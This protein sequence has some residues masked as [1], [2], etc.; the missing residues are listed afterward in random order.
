M[1][2]DYPE[3]SDITIMN[4]IYQYPRKNEETNKWSKGSMMVIAKDN[5]T[6][7]KF[8]DKEE[9]PKYAYY[10]AKE[11]VQIDHN[12]F[13]IE[14]DKVDKIEVPYI[15]LLKSIAENTDNLEFYY[16]NIKSGNRYNNTQLN[17]HPRVFSSDMSIDNF[18]R[19]E[20]SHKY[21]NNIGP[22][23]KSYLDIEADTI[24]M[25]GD[26]P[27]PGECPI[28]AV[29]VLIDSEET[30]YTFLLRNSENPLIEQFEKGLDQRF[31]QRLKD[32]VQDT[33]GGY[34]K[35]V[36]YKI[37]KL[38]YKLLFYDNE[39]DLLRDLFNLINTKEP[40]FV[41]AWN[42]A[43]DVPYII[44]RIINLGYNPEDII[45]HPDFEDKICRYYVDEKN[46][47][48]FAERGDF[49]TI[50]SYSTYV[51]QLVQFA[52]RRKGQSAF[53][54]MRLDDIGNAVAGVRKL[55]YAHITN[56][57]AKFPWL[58]YELFVM[59][60]IVDVIVQKC[61]E[62]SVGDIDYLFGKA[63]ANNTTYPKVHRQTVYLTNRAN[64]EFYK[65]GFIIGNNANRNNE[66]PPKFPGAF[67]A[68]PT[69]V[70]DYARDLINGVPVNIFRN[71]DDFDYKRLYP[72][73]LQEFNMAPNTQVGMIH[74]AEQIYAN[75]NRIKD[76]K[77]SRGGIYIENLASHNYLEF[78]KRWMHL[79]GYEDLYDD[80]IEYY[81]TIRN[82]NRMLSKV[83]DDGLLNVIHKCKKQLL[84]NPII[85][86]DN[87]QLRNV[88]VKYIPMDKKLNERCM[89]VYK[90]KGIV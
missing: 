50:S 2:I 8:Y 7:K 20:F 64:D 73:L 79:G 14:E 84:R 46:S 67:V 29:S 28:N 23:K 17:M 65:Q 9:N 18:V 35:A 5:V 82:S 25:A 15:D 76:D 34:K 75:E 33:V 26:F 43:F 86:V 80:I 81:T 30:M 49:A 68:D 13:F 51:D 44:Q 62:E 52:S 55:S 12:L 87:T 22:L 66:K 71:A 32:L 77:F 83:S 36:K 90:D 37:D 60:N 16:D 10:L 45:C 88:I 6:G 59:Y 53:P 48:M 78:C 21:T 40:D 41:L 72:S 27:Q 39:I 42:M 58:D 24:H 19:K 70:S 57:I 89:Q 63:I 31:M 74:I 3:G 61:I 1:L 56:E 11:N 38:K 69:L 4:T 47:N 85:K 54:S